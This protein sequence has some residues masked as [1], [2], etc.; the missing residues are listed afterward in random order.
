VPQQSYPKRGIVVFSVQILYIRKK[1]CFEEYGMAIQSY[2][3]DNTHKIIMIVYEESWTWQDIHNA[4]IH[5]AELMDTISY[6]VNI[7]A[8]MGRSKSVPRLSIP[9]LRRVAA[10]PA[11]SH[12]QM[13]LFY[14]A[15]AKVHIRALVD[16]FSRLFPS[17]FKQYKLV[18][19][20]DAAV[21]QIEGTVVR[22]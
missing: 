2:W 14:L 15:D 7:V 9:D 3:R 12:P 16:V 6:K 10:N 20:V 5:S 13:N 1:Y 4:L 21:E 18:K 8:D 19:S 11:A 17:A 22:S